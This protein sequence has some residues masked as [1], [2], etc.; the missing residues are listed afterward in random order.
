MKKD[1]KD[2]LNI[3]TLLLVLLVALVIFIPAWG[4]RRYMNIAILVLMYIGLGESWNL[5]SGMSGHC[6]LAD[7]QQFGNLFMT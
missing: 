1:L 6:S 3:K 4:N 7:I 2:Y 5:L